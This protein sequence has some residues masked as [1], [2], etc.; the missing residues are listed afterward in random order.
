MVK[1]SDWSIMIATA[2]VNNKDQSKQ[3]K[4]AWLKET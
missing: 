1:N 2:A 4:N 3:G